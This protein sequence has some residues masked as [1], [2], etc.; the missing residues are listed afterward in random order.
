MSKV[1]DLP[2]YNYRDIYIKEKV[3]IKGIFLLSDFNYLTILI[4]LMG[5]NWSITKH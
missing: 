3:S 1:N 4:V 2:Y 5:L